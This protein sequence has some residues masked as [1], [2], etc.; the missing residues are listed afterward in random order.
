MARVLADQSRMSGLEKAAVLMISLGP[1]I[2]AAMVRQLDETNVER[3][4]AEVAST[5]SVDMETRKEVLEEFRDMCVAFDYVARGGI[6]YARSVLEKAVGRQEAEEILSRL[7]SRFQQRPFEFARRASVDQLLS[8]LEGEHPQTMALTLCHLSPGQAAAILAELPPEQQATVA[9]RIAN[10]E[11]ISPEAIALVEQALR[12]KLSSYEGQHVNISG[13]VDAIVDILN[14][15]D[16]TTEKAILDR[17]AQNDPDL[18]EEIKERMFVFEDI[19]F[20]DDRAIQRVLRE[21]S[22][23]DVALALKTASEDVA[24]VIFQNMSSRAADALKEDLEVMGPVRLREVEEAQGRIVNIIRR[25]DELGEI[26]IARGG[27]DT[28]VV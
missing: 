14:R 12:E 4:A 25:L 17:L 20:L 22:P 10:I 3:L 24:N 28:V 23:R 1:E 2:S 7:N 9:K 26:V 19:V 11:R 5:K 16:R 21:V 13:G 6:D 15:V 8:F 27:E 18:A